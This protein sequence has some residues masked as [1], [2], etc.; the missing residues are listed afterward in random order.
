MDMKSERI[1]TT[2]GEL[3][4]AVTDATIEVTEES[5]REAYLIASL[6][7]DEILRNAP[8]RSDIGRETAYER[9]SEKLRLC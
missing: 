3:I 6:V 8:L 4:A 9:W 2:L 1:E 5:Q 7:L